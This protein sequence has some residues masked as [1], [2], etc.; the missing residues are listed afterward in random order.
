MHHQQAT[1]PVAA[2]GDADVFILRIE[3]QVPR[4]HLVP[5]YVRT[6]GVLRRCAAT[7]PDDVAAAAGV[8]ERP[9]HEAGAVQ[10]V[11]LLCTG[12]VAALGCDLCRLAPAVVSAQR[13]RFAAPEVVHLVHQRQRVSD[14]HAPFHG[15]IVRQAL[16]H[17]HGLAGGLHGVAVCDNA[18]R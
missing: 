1:Q 5:L 2:C 14:D 17:L 6:V 8:V 16:P 3:Q 10:A 18:C 12:G 7:L 13:Q 9:I 15:E 11:R 4:L